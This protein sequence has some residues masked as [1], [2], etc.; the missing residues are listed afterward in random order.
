[1][2]ARRHGRR[3]A[4]R[5]GGPPPHSPERRRGTL[6]RRGAPRGARIGGGGI[7]WVRTAAPAGAW[8]TT[9]APASAAAGGASETRARAG[10]PPPLFTRLHKPGSVSPAIEDRAPQT[11]FLQ[12]LP[13]VER[14]Y[15]YLLPLMPAAVEGWRL[16]RCD[17][18]VSLSHCVAKSVRPPRGV[19]HVC[20][21]FTPMRYAWHM[22]DAYLAGRVRGLRARAVERFLGLLRD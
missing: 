3:R 17:L 6:R 20:Y 2:Q 21:C 16:P 9:G 22:R 1:E 8:F 15:R 10:P 18:V 7:A 14:Y 4:R 13:R 19:P 12:R 5:R 11:S